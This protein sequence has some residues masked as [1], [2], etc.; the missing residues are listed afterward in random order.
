MWTPQIEF[1][2]KALMDI[3]SNLKDTEPK[4]SGKSGTT[5][6]LW[7]AVILL[8]HL[9]RANLKLNRQGM[10]LYCRHSFSSGNSIDYLA[11]LSGN[12]IFQHFHRVFCQIFVLMHKTQKVH[13]ASWMSISFSMLLWSINSR[14]QKAMHLYSCLIDFGNVTKNKM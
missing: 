4:Y 9:K 12:G 8:S 13:V 5:F 11:C 1:F 2:I 7:C 14:W 10:R 6:C 3:K